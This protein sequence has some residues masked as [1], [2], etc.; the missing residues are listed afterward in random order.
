MMRR[1]DF[2]K[3]SLLGGVSLVGLPRLAAAAEDAAEDKAAGLGYRL[4]RDTPTRRYDGRTCWC[5][6]RAGIVPGSARTACR[7]S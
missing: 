4:T 3:S 7:A 5:H 1:R 2:S 6:P